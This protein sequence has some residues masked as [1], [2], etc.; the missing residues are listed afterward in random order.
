MKRIV[1]LNFP[2][3]FEF[4]KEFDHGNCEPCP[5]FQEDDELSELDRCFTPAGSY[6]CPFYGKAEDEVI[7]I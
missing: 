3:D 4:P 7:E 2:D 5:F 1:K 6:A